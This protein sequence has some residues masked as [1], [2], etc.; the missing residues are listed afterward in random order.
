MV[1]LRVENYIRP[2][3]PTKRCA[4]ARQPHRAKLKHWKIHVKE[5]VLA[6]SKCPSL[7]AASRLQGSMRLAWYPVFLSCRG[8]NIHH[9]NSKLWRR[10]IFCTSIQLLCTF[11][12][13]N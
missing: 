7:D 8:S 2:K 6:S 4:N 12:A 3:Q 9:H 13:T 10:S 5:F 11:T 1:D